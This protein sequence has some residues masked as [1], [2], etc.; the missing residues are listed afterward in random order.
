MVIN[1]KEARLIFQM[2]QDNYDN[3]L[4][5]QEMLEFIQKVSA[6]MCHMDPPSTAV[7]VRGQPP[8]PVRHALAW[9]DGL[10]AP[11]ASVPGDVTNGQPGTGTGTGT[12]EAAL[13]REDTH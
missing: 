10:R 8:P 4:L 11:T 7:F 9:V 5:N 3:E 1:E 6:N 12:K 13:N 2:G